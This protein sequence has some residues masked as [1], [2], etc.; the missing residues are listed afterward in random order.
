MSRRY[1]EPVRVR[2][3]PSASTSTSADDASAEA[4]A[5]F[6]WRGRRYV[7]RQ[8]LAH[9]IEGGSWWRR[10]QHSAERQVWRVEA[11]VVRSATVGVY[12]LCCTRSPVDR[13]HLARA[14]D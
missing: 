7:V 5:E 2:T 6:L 14:L 3:S 1:L 13:W 4:P 8:V 11:G 9:W 12:D 10:P